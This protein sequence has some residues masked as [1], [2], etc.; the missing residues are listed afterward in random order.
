[1]EFVE[2]S[3]DYL[4]R[5]EGYIV[6]VVHPPSGY[7]TD[8]DGSLEFAVIDA[9]AV[10]AFAPGISRLGYDSSHTHAM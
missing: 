4:G 1:M 2:V 5:S 10:D 9:N 7:L 3:C 8:A 6:F